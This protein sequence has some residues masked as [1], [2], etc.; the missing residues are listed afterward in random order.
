[1]LPVRDHLPARR[2]PLVNYG[3]L[4]ANVLAFMWERSLL[5]QGVPPGAI[6][7]HFGLTPAILTS[8]PMEGAPTLLTSMFLHDPTGWLHIGG[9]LLFLWVFGDNVEDALGHVRYL[10]FYLACGL[11]AA[12][13]QV[14]V[15]PDSW[16]PMVGASGA[17]SGVLAA[18][19]SLYPRAPI[20]VLNP[21]LPLWFVLGVF[22]D[23]PAW[24]I[25]AEYFLVNLLSVIEAPGADTGG[26]A[27][28]AHLGGFVAG[29]LLVR[30]ALPR[31][32]PGPRSRRPALHSAERRA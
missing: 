1:M 20:T 32:P 22:L 8:N 17:I 29:I 6:V 2:V 3:L 24:L 27:F 19:G 13:G 15:A 30:V 26:V 9:N 10:A 4:V 28:F 16:V 18:Y 11:L 5:A 14:M 23:I 25:I 12:G 7:R 21:V 31:R